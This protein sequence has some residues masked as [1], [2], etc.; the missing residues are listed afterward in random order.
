MS[1]WLKQ[2]NL[3]RS[4]NKLLHL[5]ADQFYSILGKRVKDRHAQS[6]KMILQ[7]KFVQVLKENKEKNILMKCHWSYTLLLANTVM[8]ELT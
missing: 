5:L 4:S 8:T 1:F 3:V 7:E 2:N 6:I